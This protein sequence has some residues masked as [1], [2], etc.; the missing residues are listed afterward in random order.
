MKD[1]LRFAAFAVLNAL[2]NL[3]CYRTPGA[4]PAAQFAL[5]I[6]LLAASFA[7]YAGT[8]YSAYKRVRNY[9]VREN[10]LLELGDRKLRYSYYDA[11]SHMIVQYEIP[12]SELH[13]IERHARM[14]LWRLTGDFELKLFFGDRT[15]E[16]PAVT[17]TPGLLL[18]DYFEGVDDL[19]KSLSDLRN[20]R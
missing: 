18:G 15:D 10:E 4:L 8:L 3:I 2:F 12:I 16:S 14:P 6:G 5:C 7:L 17:T 19:C 11:H 20:G 13:N 1:I 9:S